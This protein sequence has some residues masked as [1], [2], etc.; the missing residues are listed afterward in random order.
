MVAGFF[1]APRGGVDH[2]SLQPVRRAGGAEEVVD[3]DAGVAGPAAGLIIPEGELV[4]L[5]VEN[6]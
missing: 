4:R 3:A 6:P 2:A 5:V 1:F